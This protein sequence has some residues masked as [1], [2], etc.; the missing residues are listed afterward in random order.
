MASAE[1][2]SL[3]VE[4]DLAARLKAMRHEEPEALEEEPEYEAWVPS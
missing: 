1:P 3:Q 4:D 2:P